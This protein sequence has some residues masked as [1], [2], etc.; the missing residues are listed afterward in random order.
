MDNRSFWFYQFYEKE[1]L[2]LYYK[3]RE[4]SLSLFEAGVPILWGFPDVFGLF[5]PL[6]V[7]EISFRYS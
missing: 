3:Y 4:S 5:G 6:K 7:G 2:V 1:I